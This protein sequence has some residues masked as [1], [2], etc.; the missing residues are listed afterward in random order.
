MIVY[1]NEL[2]H[3]TRGQAKKLF[4]ALTCNNKF[5]HC[6]NAESGHGGHCQPLSHYHNNEH[7]FNFL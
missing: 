3:I 7:L 1:D 2:E 4:D 6:F 5:Y